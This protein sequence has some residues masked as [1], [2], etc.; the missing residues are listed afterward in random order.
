MIGNFAL[1]L[2]IIMAVFLFYYAITDMKQKN[3]S[4]FSLHIIFII[5]MAFVFSGVAYLF[6]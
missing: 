3:K 4:V 1:G 5:V 6:I 2:S